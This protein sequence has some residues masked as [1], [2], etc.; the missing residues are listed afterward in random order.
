MDQLVS[1]VPQILEQGL[2]EIINVANVKKDN[3][4]L[5][6]YFNFINFLFRGATNFVPCMEQENN[7]NVLFQN[8]QHCTSGYLN[9]DQLM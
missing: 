7:V 8:N 9:D 6:L 1:R 2:S 5:S 3:D 4:K